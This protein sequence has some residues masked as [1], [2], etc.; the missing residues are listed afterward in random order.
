MRIPLMAR[1][2]P[3]ALLAAPA[4][5]AAAQALP[6]S[7]FSR[8]EYEVRESGPLRFA[9][10]DRATVRLREHGGAEAAVLEVFPEWFPLSEPVGAQAAG[11]ME[12]MD[13]VRD[14]APREGARLVV[15]DLPAYELVADARSAAGAPL[16]LY[17]VTI[18]ELGRLV[19]L[20]GRMAADAER[21]LL[22]H[23]RRVARSF[24]RTAVL[25]Q[26]LG[27][28]GY[29]VTGGYQPVAALSDARM[30]VYHDPRTHSSLF[31]ALLGDAADRNAVAAEAM[32]RLFTADRPGD[33][34]PTQWQRLSAFRLSPGEVHAERRMAR[35]GRGI[36]VVIRH[37]RNGGQD[38]LTGYAYASRVPNSDSYPAGQASAWLIRS[39]GHE[40]G[41]DAFAPI[42]VGPPA[43]V[44]APPPGKRP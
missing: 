26:R 22:P 37:L 30:A 9:G 33:P 29:E 3:V 4:L 18:P 24:R 31:V 41:D 16:V 17:Q 28:V 13:G 25:R 6:D 14:V 10:R 32:R 34:Q 11:W 36:I 19:V 1:A 38:W 7:L 21:R 8:L 43:A 35:S 15:D 5:P 2:L 20:R 27:A 12:R 40:V 39:A 44:S 23:F 42:I